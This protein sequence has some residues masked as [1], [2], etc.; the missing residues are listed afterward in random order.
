M[1]GNQAAGVRAPSPRNG[2]GGAGPGGFSPAN[3]KNAGAA[4]LENANR[5][6]AQQKKYGVSPGMAAALGGMQPRQA[7]PRP[8]AAG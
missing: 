1:G 6:L 2:Y 3:A 5:F 4:R 7:P 8:N